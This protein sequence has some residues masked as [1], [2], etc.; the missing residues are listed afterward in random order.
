MPTAPTKPKIKPRPKGA[1]EPKTNP[2]PPEKWC[3]DQVKRI[4]DA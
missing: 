3:P 1:P 4:F 2:F